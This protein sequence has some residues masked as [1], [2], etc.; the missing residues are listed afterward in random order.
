MTCFLFSVEN[1]YH[2]IM[3]GKKQFK[4]KNKSYVSVFFLFSKTNINHFLFEINLY[5]EILQNFNRILWVDV[6]L[7]KFNF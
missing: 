4:M 7:C 5:L 6:L 3:M 1:V 2:C